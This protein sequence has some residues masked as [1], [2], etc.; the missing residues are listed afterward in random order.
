MTGVTTECAAGERMFAYA[1]STFMGERTVLGEHMPDYGMDGTYG[2]FPTRRDAQLAAQRH[3]RLL[4]KA[5]WDAVRTLTYTATFPPA[6]RCTY[7]LI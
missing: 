7:G 2:T 5:G 3:R 4:L 6:N 1:V